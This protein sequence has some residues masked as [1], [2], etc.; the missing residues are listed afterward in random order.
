[1]I[2]SSTPSA[3]PEHRSRPVKR[4]SSPA[5]GPLSSARSGLADPEPASVLELQVRADVRRQR[6]DDALELIGRFARIELAVLGPDLLRV[7]RERVILRRAL[8]PA[9]KHAHQ[10]LGAAALQ[11]RREAAVGVERG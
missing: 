4:E 2:S 3:Q 9:V 8:G 11:P 6:P 5:G 7:G 10:Q 1:M